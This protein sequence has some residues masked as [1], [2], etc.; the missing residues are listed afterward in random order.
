[1]FK[2][3]GSNKKTGQYG[4]DEASKFLQKQGYKILERNFRYSRLAEIDI[5]AKDKDTIV[6]VEVKTRKTLNCGHP[7]EAVDYKKLEHIYKAGLAYLK[8]TEEEYKNFRIDI[9]S[10]LGVQNPKIEHLKDV[11]LN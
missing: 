1:M 11:S 4:E 2:I 3:F 6:F 9:I 5:I 7:F 10:V 8:A